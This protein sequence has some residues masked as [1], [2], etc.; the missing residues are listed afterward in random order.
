M[1]V[2]WM[3]ARKTPIR[4]VKSAKIQIKIPLN[5]CFFFIFK[6]K[7]IY[8]HKKKWN[9]W[10]KFHLFITLLFLF[11]SNEF[12]VQTFKKNAALNAFFSNSLPF[13]HDAKKFVEF[14]ILLSIIY[15]NLHISPSL[16][17]YVHLCRKYIVDC[18]FP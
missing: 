6:I 15:I 1:C 4:K 10:K 13:I 17:D 3:R 18:H 5:V 8:T 7:Y 11:N 16:W 12:F 9:Q 14:L 2:V